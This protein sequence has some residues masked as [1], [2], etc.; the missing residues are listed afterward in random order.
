M[1]YKGKK[2]RNVIRF[3]NRYIQQHVT[4]SFQIRPM[5]NFVKS[6]NW[7]D[8][9]GVEIGVL[10]GKNSY[11]ILSNLSIKKLYL[12]DPYQT[13]NEEINIYD[14]N[15]KDFEQAYQLLKSFQNKCFIIKPS[16]DAVTE[17]QSNLDFVYIDGNHDYEHVK[18]DIELYYQ[19]V[20][21]GGVIGGHDFRPNYE[22]LCRA[23]LEF[24]DKEKLKLQGWKTD[25]WV[26][27]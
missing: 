16:E 1:E 15:N 19:K 25:W 21:P 11:S 8:I 24:V 20:R 4:Y 3:L 12:V 10:Y 22:G 17:I 18:K 23:V 26:E 9:V 14:R 27:K 5:I 13:Y 2:V 7:N 6:K